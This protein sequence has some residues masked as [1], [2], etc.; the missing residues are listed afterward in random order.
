MTTPIP[1]SEFEQRWKRTQEACRE[2]GLDGLVAISRCG[3]IPD[4]YADVMYLANHY[5]PFVLCQDVPRWWVGRS[6]AAIV[7]PLDR[8]PMLVLD[9]P[10][11]RRDLVVVDDV[12]LSFNVPRGTAE[13][14]AEFG[15]ADGR[16]GFA[17]GN[18]ML[19]S[20]Y[21]TLLEELPGAELVPADDLMES[22]RV[23]KSP[24]ELDLLREASEIGSR[25]MQ[26]MMEK[27][28]KPGT[29]E[30]EAVAEGMDIAV[31]SLINVYDVAVASGPNSL[32]YTFG[33]LPSWT[34]RTLEEG[35]FFHVDTYGAHEGYLYDFSR[36]VVVGGKPSSEQVEVLDAA[37]D[38]IDAGVEAIRPG[39]R[40][41]EVYDAVRNV[42]EERG[43]TGEGFMGDISD[44]PALTS[45]FPGHGHSIGLFWEAPWLFEDEEQE[46]PANSCYGI[47]CMA[48]GPDVGSAKF[49]QDVIVTDQGTE[50]IT[51]T[52][53]RFW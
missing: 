44:T 13:A 48:G 42:L 4:S 33:R 51:K 9:V 8:E 27:A 10:D 7:L 47:E 43:M 22:I 20:P 35:D 32:Y 46:V 50:L 15:L 17:G 49:E 3:A 2:A 16:L 5:D 21:R 38:A 26:A 28:L 6:H 29:T 39:I 41:R 11:W 34:S 37:I 12:R 14:L 40:A 31:K 25:V 1:K 45:A 18:A 36:T 52:D 53:K 19:V 30:A 24:R 23:T